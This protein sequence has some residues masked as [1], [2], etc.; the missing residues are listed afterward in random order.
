MK[1][2]LRNFVKWMVPLSFGLVL[3][4]CSNEDEKPQEGNS[5]VTL[6]STAQGESGSSSENG[7]VEV[8]AMSV[9]SFQVGTQDAEMKYVAKAEIDAGI[10]IG[11]GTLLSNVSTELG[12]SSSQQKNLSL[13][14]EGDSKVE[15]IGEG[16]TPNGNYTEVVFKLYQNTNAGSNSEMQDKSLLIMGEANGKP[17]ELWMEAEKELRATSESAQGY[18]VDG[19]TDMTIIFDMEQMFSGVDMSAA[20]DLDADGTIE[21]GP[22]VAENQAIYSQVESNISSSVKFVK[23]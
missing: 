17:V 3:V 9:S 23:Q 15:V 14:A 19:D 20:S 22:G 1:K 21:I 6:K 8:G 13:I 11:N 12:A 18:E 16:E 4:A 10:S 5:N 2:Q 7:R